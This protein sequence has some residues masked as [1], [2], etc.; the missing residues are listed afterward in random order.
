MK[1]T[2]IIRKK[3]PAAAVILL[4]LFCWAGTAAAATT[5]GTDNT[6]Q[7]ELTI[8]G[9]L[10]SID[11]TLKYSVPPGSG[12]S[13]G[14]DA[15]DILDS[16]NFVFMAAGEARYNKLSFGMDLIYMDVSN[17]KNT[18]ILVGPAQDTTLSVAAKLS[19]STWLV[20][21]IVGYDL[22]QSDE[23]RLAV[24]GGLRYL[25]LDADTSL[26]INGP[27]PPTPPP[28]YLSKSDDFW[29]G[30]VGIKGA[31]MLNKNWYIPYYADIGAGDS[32][33]T[34]QL[35]AAIGYMFHWGDIRLGYRYLEYDQDDDKFV[36]DL[37][38]YGPV[39][40]IGFRF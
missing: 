25:S 3:S 39:V 26:S 12:S 16:L 27:L 38:F 11:G 18:S 9:W 35:Y 37:K 20:T 28:A 6:W 33:L 17:S 2:K 22:I 29:D 8:Y 21:G 23:N 5:A 30:I 24:V 13:V 19:L 31:F 15:S 40:G 1:L 4:L 7:Y 14:V 32:Q 10:P 34:W 36:Q